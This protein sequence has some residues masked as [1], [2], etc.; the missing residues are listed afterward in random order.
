MFEKEY[1]APEAEV[2]SWARINEVYAMSNTEFISFYR[3][4]IDD[5]CGIQVTS[6]KNLGYAIAYLVYLD[7]R[8]IKEFDEKD[9]NNICEALPKYW[10][11][12]QDEESVYDAHI[13]FSRGV[14]FSI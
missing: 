13:A 6:M 5:I 12:F 7:S 2:R 11:A 8:T 4:L 14:K 3:S 1:F 10:E 9:F